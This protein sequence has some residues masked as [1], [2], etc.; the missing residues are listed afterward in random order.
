MF[1]RKPTINNNTKP[2]ASGSGGVSTR[3]PFA[4]VIDACGQSARAYEPV[5]AN[6]VVDWY[7]AMPE[8]IEAI[9]RML[10]TQGEKNTEQF[11]MY[12]A[13]GA[14]ARQ[15]GDQF[16][17]YKD[18]CDDARLAF[19]RAHADDLER[20]RNPRRFQERWDIAANRE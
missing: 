18:V 5:N 19:E 3:N 20:I 6:R 17:R 15:L 7:A 16:R 1:E 8:L 2:A 10:S 14:F 12:P 4:A 9:A 13:A 11:F